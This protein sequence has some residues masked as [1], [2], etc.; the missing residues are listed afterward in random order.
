MGLLGYDQGAVHT[1]ALEDIRRAMGQA[2]ATHCPQEPLHLE[3][4]IRFANDLADLWYLRPE[5]MQTIASSTNERV[6]HQV[7]RDI[8]AMFR[9][10]FSGAD[11]S[12]F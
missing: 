4:A 12:R 7:L 1:A 8:T 3:M 10:H 5:L 6:A 11:T 9:G 2:L